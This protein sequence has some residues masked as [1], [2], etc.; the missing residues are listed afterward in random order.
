MAIKIKNG[1]DYDNISIVPCGTSSVLHRSDCDT[2]QD[3][4]GLKLKLPLISSPMSTVT[5]GELAKKMWELGCFGFIHRFLSIK[6]QVEE[7]SLATRDYAV[8]GCAIGAIGDYLER[9]DE[10]TTVGCKHICIDI[11]HGNSL[12]M[13]LAVRKIRSQSKYNHIKLIGGNVATA[14]GFKY[15]SELGLDAVRILIGSGSRCKTRYTTAVFVPPI[16]ALVDCLEER[17]KIN[18]KV[19]IIACGGI[20]NQADFCK[21]I[22]IGSDVCMCGSLIASCDES[23]AAF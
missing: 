8:A 5:N 23:P 13:G 14:D 10:L 22:A 16:T 4:I 17:E 18:S 15:L 7:Y 3:F 12:V 2:T 1:L 6:D 20:K 21:S 9:L 11:A 19:Q